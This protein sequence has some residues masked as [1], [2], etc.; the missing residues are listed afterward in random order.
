M[1]IDRTNFMTFEPGQFN[2]KQFSEKFN[3]PDLYYKL[4][5]CIETEYT[6]QINEPFFVVHGWMDVYPT[7][8]LKAMGLLHC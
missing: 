5:I 7:C 8:V 6:V 1:T 3:K 2:P 4:D